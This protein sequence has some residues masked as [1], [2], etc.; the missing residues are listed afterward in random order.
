MFAYDN[1]SKRPAGTST[2]GRVRE[3]NRQDRGWSERISTSSVLVILSALVLGG[4]AKALSF[5]P[6]AACGATVL[7]L[8][9]TESEGACAEEP[10]WVNQLS[11]ASA[12]LLYL[13]LG[14]CLGLVVLVLMP[15]VLHLARR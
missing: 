14:Y 10:A 12:G 9:W 8:A 11:L 1:I 15:L 3:L 4:V 7:V 13:G 2:L 6:L 5:V